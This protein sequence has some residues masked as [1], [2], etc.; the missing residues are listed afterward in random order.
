MLN[1]IKIDVSL[2]HN[3]TASTYHL[4]QPTE[5]KNALNKITQ[6]E[7]TYDHILEI[8]GSWH[9]YQYLVKVSKEMDLEKIKQKISKLIK[10]SKEIEQELFDSELIMFWSF[11]VDYSGFHT[12]KSM[13]NLVNYFNKKNGSPFSR[14]AIIKRAYFEL[15]FIAET[16]GIIPPKLNYERSD[17]KTYLQILLAHLKIKEKTFENYYQA[18]IKA[19]TKPEVENKISAF[20]QTC[21]EFHNDISVWRHFL[22]I[23]RREIAPLLFPQ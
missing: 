20:I 16:L 13:D 8:I 15:I 14:N 21:T 17:F 5:I 2:L 22:T 7:V 3:V 9:T 19:K 4:E 6:Y 23:Y 1:N 11:G 10:I 18:Y 12:P